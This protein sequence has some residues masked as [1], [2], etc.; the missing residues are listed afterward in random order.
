[1]ASAS[2]LEEL[3]MTRDEVERFAK[4]FKDEKFRKMLAEYAEEI[5]S[6]ENK[7]KYEEEITQLE[8]ERGVE[9]KFVHPKPGHVLKTSVDGDKKCFINVCSNDLIN[10]PVCKAGKGSNGTV[11]QHWSLPYSLT[12]GREDLGAGGRKHMI[13][14]VV[15]HP[16][17]LYMADKNKKFR[18]MVDQ[19]AIDMIEKQ[20]NAKLD[21]RNV[22][23]LK[24]KYKGLPHAAVIRKPLP[25]GPKEPPDEDNPL[26]FPYP[27][28]RPKSE[29]ASKNDTKDKT[30]KCS[31][32]AAEDNKKTQDSKFTQPKYSIVYRSHFEMQDYRYARDAAP[33]TR[34]KELVV[35][36]DLP[37]LK[38]AE[39]ACLDVTE[40]LLCLE[41][42]NPAY[43]LD[44][45]LPYPVDENL[46]SAE[47]NK[48]KRQLVV[49]LPV[50]PMKQVRVQEMEQDHGSDFEQTGVNNESTE[51]GQSLCESELFQLERCSHQENIVCD[52][53]CVNREA[54]SELVRALQDSN[55][56]QS[57]NI[58]CA[59]TCV[60]PETESELVSALQDSN[61][62]QSQNIVCAS[63]CANPDTESELVSALQDS[64]LDQSQNNEHLELSQIKTSTES[65][66]KAAVASV[67][68]NSFLKPNDVIVYPTMVSE[69]DSEEQKNLPKEGAVA[70]TDKG[71]LGSLE[72]ACS[73][74]V[75]GQV[76]DHPQVDSSANTT[77]CSED[78]LKE[79]EPACPDFHYHQNEGSITFILQVRNINE[80][81]LKSV[82]HTH[83]YSVV[84]G[85]KDSDAKYSLIIQFPSEHQLDITESILNISED[86]AAVV[87]IKSHES[88]GLWQS[89]HAGNTHNCLEKFFV[90]SENVD[91]FLSASLEDPVPNKLS[92][93]H[94][95]VIRVSEV[96]E[97]GLVIHSEQE[98]EDTSSHELALKPDIINHYEACNTASNIQQHTEEICF[99]ESIAR[100][101]KLKKE[102]P[103]T[104]DPV[105]FVSSHR[106]QLVA[107]SGNYG[108]FAQTSNAAEGTKMKIPW[109]EMAHLTQGSCLNPVDESK[110]ISEVEIK[111]QSIMP[112]SD[113]NTVQAEDPISVNCK[114]PVNFK[115][116]VKME[117]GNVLDEDD[118][119]TEQKS[120]DSSEFIKPSAAPQILEEMN[121]ADESVEI[122]SD[123]KTHSAF[124]FQNTELY[125]LD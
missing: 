67:S 83:E 57:Q 23:T 85:T 88:G 30:S 22:K 103:L 1:M 45:F 116:C 94:P 33:S 40:K 106:D 16:D 110:L 55:L 27:F 66:V 78:Y 109:N 113:L 122:I 19:T 93:K 42:Q 4:A 99:S 111:S 102:T 79:T 13:Y 70:S 24:V 58:V 73:S 12:P 46:G 65:V 54:E 49:T 75:G 7:K 28:D 76:N 124:I 114:K 2:K 92:E 107:V 32:A 8:K 9:V 98:K 115:R 90:T 15:F 38:S 34:P 84:F 63:T 31:K 69:V 44:L 10:K 68:N 21:V 120:G 41:S 89:F 29:N 71:F 48:S 72:K 36:I 104:D 25:G 60:N 62:E 20:L 61:L 86:N 87:L 52:S 74:T 125:Q 17:T 105:E 51:S 108:N 95:A 6:P 77:F 59:S 97:S 39:D 80:E 101:N 123:H 35:S 112:P 91:Q 121:P 119:P 11:G 118:L 26:K 37:L 100:D 117:D 43:K 14:D 47:F 81:S 18:K 96:S 64:N 53:A 82:L 3:D 5:S 56:E 50:V